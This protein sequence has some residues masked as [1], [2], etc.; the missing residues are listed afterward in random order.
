VYALLESLLD[1]PM[2]FPA[3]GG[4]VGDVECGTTVRRPVDAVGA[5]AVRADGR[6]R[7]SGA[8]QGAT[9]HVFAVR[10]SILFMAIAAEP[11]LAV[12]EH[13]RSTVPNREHAVCLRPMARATIERQCAIRPGLL[14]RLAVYARSQPR[15]LYRVTPGTSFPHVEGGLSK[16]VFFGMSL[17]DLLGFV[18]AAVAIMAVHALLEVDIV[19]HSVAGNVEVAALLVPQILVPVTLQA[20]VL[21]RRE[22]GAC[23]RPSQRR[24]GR[25]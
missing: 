21:V 14:S 18:A 4:H 16:A 11:D 10:V 3:G 6:D 9:V 2:T 22:V 13:G 17:V 20:Q 15:L 24:L 5:V 25:G 7:E 12:Q 1:E 23:D 19:G 8:F